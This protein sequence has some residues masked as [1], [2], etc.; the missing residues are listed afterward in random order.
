MLT[1]DDRRLLT[2][3]ADTLD[4]ADAAIRDATALGCDPKAMAAGIRA[5]VDRPAPTP[6]AA[7]GVDLDAV[8]R[9]ERAM[10]PGEWRH[11]SVERHHIFCGE[12]DQSL[13]CPEAGRV[14]LRMNEHF[15]H[16]RDA[17]GIVA[18][19]NAAPALIAEVRALRAA[20]EEREADMHARIRAG[21]DKTVADA[22]R[23]E[24]AKRDAEIADLRA[25]VESQRRDYLDVCDAIAPETSG[26]A[27]AAAKV[28][29]LR[30]HYDAAGPDHN[31]LALLD[32]Y[33]EREQAALAKLAEA[34]R[35]GLEACDF[36]G[37]IG[38]EDSYSTH[39]A[40]RIAA[41][42]GAL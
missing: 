40:V 1:A 32:L 10:T 27:D 11:G 42:L 7:A 24:V 37:R 12:G 8:E 16:D 29:A 38:A 5:I 3:A 31:L 6:A 19:R 33:H 36:F 23:A 18:L 41:T 9:A 34:K 25:L 15:P 22:W 20:A 28:R 21:Y 14:L 39:T 35:L 17:A 13:L 4:D 30:R 26:P 2:D